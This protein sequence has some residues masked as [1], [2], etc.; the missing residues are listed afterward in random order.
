MFSIGAF[1]WFNL[2]N[3]F[4]EAGEMEKPALFQI[5]TYLPL[6]GGGAFAIYLE[7]PLPVHFQIFALLLSTCQ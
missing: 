2:I 6:G 5:G 3:W 4:W 1:I 7:F